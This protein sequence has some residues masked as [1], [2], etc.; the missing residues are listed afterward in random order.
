MTID[1]FVFAGEQSGD[2]HGE[3]ILNALKDI[4]PELRIAGVGGPKMRAQGM[5]CVEKME[6]FRVMGFTDVIKNLFTL[7]RLFRK[8]RKKIID[9]HP[10]AVLFIDY[11]DFNMLMAKSLRKKNFSGKL[12]HYVCPTVWAWRKK[13]V[14]TLVKTLDLL[15]T[16]FPFEQKYFANTTLKTLYVGNPIVNSI[17]KLPSPSE[18]SIK[19]CVG[20]FP[21]SRHGEVMRN[22]P[23]QLQVASSVPHQNFAISIAHESLEPMIK[24]IIAAHAP[25]LDII[26]VMPHQSY[27]LMRSCTAAIATSGTVNLELALFEIPTIVTYQLTS[28]NLFLA[29]HIFRINLPRYCI[30]NI[31]ANKTIFPEFI[32]EFTID[33]L[34][35]TFHDLLFSPKCRK[36]CIAGC[37]EVKKLLSNNNAA[38]KA[39]QAIKELVI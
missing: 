30:V 14:K 9:M 20:I 22:L 2:L 18:S 23:T 19:P 13:R 38:L 17:D 37:Q 34:Q 8:V 5:V 25:H 35:T 10:K 11:P 27:D 15:M 36:K 16:I 32:Q 33:D 6:S 1:L 26:Y 39:A 28:L 29:K 24:E 7:W 31:I 4:A 3:K 21:G 12:I